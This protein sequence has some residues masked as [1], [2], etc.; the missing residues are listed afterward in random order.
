[1]PKIMKTRP[2]FISHA[3]DDFVKQL[4]L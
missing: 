4:R 3:D 2:I 1:M